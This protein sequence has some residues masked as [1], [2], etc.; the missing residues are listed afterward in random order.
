[1]TRSF[2]RAAERLAT[3]F[4]WVAGLLLLATTS[5]ILFDIAFRRLAG[6]STFISQEYSGYFMAAM[7]YMAA[8]YTLLKGEHI[9][10]G[11]VRERLS[12]RGQRI[13]DLI[14]GVLGTIFAT[15][16]TY[17][18]FKQTLD[19]WVYGT[20]SFLPSRTPLVYP[21][22]SAFLGSLVLLTSFIAFT[23]KSWLGEEA[24]S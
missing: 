13:M 14:A 10:V 15:L 23:L 4:G 20:R 5:L 8:G 19:A 9:R 24:E 17:A 16:L 11:L 3:L 6:R 18:L 1:M 12:P 2:I 21:Y 22:S 7:V